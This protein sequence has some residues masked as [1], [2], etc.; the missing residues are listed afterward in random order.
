M[1]KLGD[2]VWWLGEF[3]RAESLYEEAHHL[4]LQENRPRDAAMS[5]LAL[6][7]LA[8][9]RGEMAFGSGWMGRGTRL[10]EGQ[11]AGR[12]HGY[13]LFMDVSG[14]L[15][16][17]DFAA[18][19]DQARRLQ[20]VGRTHGDPNLVALGI[21]CEGQALLKQGS[22][23][24]G[25]RLLDEAMLAAVSD[26]LD[27]EWAGNIYC[28]LM[29][30]CHEL[31]DLERA[32]AWTQATVSWCESLPAAGPFLG[33]CRVHRAQILHIQGEWSR[34][35]VE[36]ARVCKELADFDLGTVAEGYYQLGEVR[37]LRGDLAGAEEAFRQSHAV[38]RDPQPG[39]ALLR[40]GQNR[41]EEAVS[42]IHSALSTGPQD[43][44]RRAWLCAACVE[45]SL[46]AGLLDAA[47]L[48]CDELQAA[49]ENF[50]SSVLSACAAQGDG[51]V[52]LHEGKPEQA[53]RSLRLAG[54]RWQ[55]LG[56]PYE[57]ARVRVLLAQ[58]YEAV[59]DRSAANLELDAAEQVFQSLGAKP[60][61]VMVTALRQGPHTRQPGGLTKRELEI[62]ALV[63]SGQTNRA[64]AEA[65]T[66]SEKTVARHLTNIY[67]KLGLSSRTE[68]ARFAFEHGLTGRPIRRMS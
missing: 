25:M 8:F 5:A 18:A 24:E 62:L 52:L 45:I 11:P 37:R 68:A 67:S 3:R 66:L 35:E 55:K 21:L 33:V 29:V 9:M 12:E 6:A 28:Q 60:D 17:G 50:E 54:L 10:L 43:A 40:L 13:I 48:S 42:S 15:Q 59:G 41:I 7:G 64:I 32:R 65:L 39:L 57:S 31:G 63:S 61:V 53:V 22:F 56:A 23:K 51:A 46:A 2:C 58:A 19:T 36:A 44:L 14:S 47:R 49:A 30:A 27:P 34:A 4:Y 20:E 16:S 26:K 1:F 38:G